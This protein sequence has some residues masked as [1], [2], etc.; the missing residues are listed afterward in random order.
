MGRI[1]ATCGHE[2]TEEWDHSGKGHIIYRHEN[3]ECIMVDD[4]IVVCPDCLGLY[5]M[6]SEDED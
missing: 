6:L 5:E 4:S 1:I 2:I 3:R